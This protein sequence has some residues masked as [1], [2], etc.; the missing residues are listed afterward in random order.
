MR[1]LDRKRNEGRGKEERER[2][3]ERETESEAERNRECDK[4][5]IH[6]KSQSGMTREDVTCFG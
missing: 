2:E 3:R 5:W 4:R 6:V 1:I